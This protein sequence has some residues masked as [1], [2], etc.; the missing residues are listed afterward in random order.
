MFKISEKG[1][2]IT[3]LEHFKNFVGHEYK[4]WAF[5]FGIDSISDSISDGVIGV[6]KKDVLC[7]ICS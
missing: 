4:P 5:L 7:R 1:L 3:L 2:L 6:Q